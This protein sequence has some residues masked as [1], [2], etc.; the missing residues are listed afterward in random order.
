MTNLL[1]I[2]Y[3][4]SFRNGAIVG[5]SISQTADARLANSGVS[6][7]DGE[8]ALPGPGIASIP[9]MKATPFMGP[10]CRHWGD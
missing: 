8:P 4:V 3:L 10:L 9:G 1:P 2:S 6:V 7:D 5:A